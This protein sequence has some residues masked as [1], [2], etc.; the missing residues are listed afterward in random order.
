VRSQLLLLSLKQGVE[1][2]KDSHYYQQ[3]PSVTSFI[4]AAAAAAAVAEG[5]SGQ[6]ELPYPLLLLLLPPPWQPV[7]AELHSHS[8]H[9]YVEYS[10]SCHLTP[11]VIAA[12]AIAACQGRAT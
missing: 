4:S 9:S 8:Q 3:L 1:A 10:N 5:C 12:A 6:D 2:K 7:E 11:A